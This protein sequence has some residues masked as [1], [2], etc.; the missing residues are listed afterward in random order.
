MELDKSF[1]QCS[2]VDNADV[3]IPHGPTSDQDERKTPVLSGRPNDAIKPGLPAERLVA[4]DAF[5]G[6]TIL[7]MLLVNNTAMGAATPK[8]FL[9]AE[10]NGGVH[11]A[12][13]VFPWFL[14]I[15]GVAIP[16]AFASHLRKGLSLP[17]HLLKAA[18]RTAVLFLLGCFIDSSIAKQPIIGLGVLQLIG[19]AYFAGVL[20]YQLPAVWRLATA[21]GLLV[22]HWAA[23]RFIP[24]PD[25]GAGAFRE[26]G[27]LIY[28]LN[29]AYLHRYHLNGIISVIPTSALVIIGAF[30]GDL[31]RDD[32]KRPEIKVMCMLVGG[33]VLALIG[34]LWN[35]DLPF[36]KPLWTASYILY[37]AGL[38]SVVLG[39]LYLVIDIRKCRLWAF[40]LIVFGTNAI[41]AYVL[42]IA[43]KVYIFQGW[44]V[45]MP[46][47]SELPLQ[48]AALQWLTTYA[49]SA[50]GG[51][52]YTSGYIVFWWFVILL[53][54]RKK[55]F[56]RA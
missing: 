27:N 14:F 40:P 21:L 49:G 42:P 56:L 51:W 17:Q 46:N 25:Q 53:F 16:Y 39:L 32:K 20:I 35:L 5:R 43:V 28:Y 30:V 34:W 47:G 45:S 33:G 7:G 19:L 9:H 2:R 31:L 50:C 48:Q 13:L 1:Q 11:F 26:T 12:D 36:N 4:L 6:L 41:L 8:Q 29:E 44:M 24:I 22:A 55:I 18:D 38:G 37:T 3:Y 10:W 54:Y 15:V 52:L 23:I